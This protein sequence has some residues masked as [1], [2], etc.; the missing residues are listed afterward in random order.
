MRPIRKEISLSLGAICLVLA[1]CGGGDDA[2]AG[3]G[4]GNGLGALGTS[5]DV[6]Q[7]YDS[8]GRSI[9]PMYCIRPQEGSDWADV[10]SSSATLSMALESDR[11][12]IARSIGVDIK[13]SYSIV[14]ASTSFYRATETD[15]FSAA[16]VFGGAISFKE[17]QVGPDYMV[18]PLLAA[19]NPVEW[20]E[21]CGDSFVHGISRGASLYAAMKFHFKSRSEK[22]TFEAKMKVSSG[23]FSVSSAL[24]TAQ[25]ISTQGVSVSVSAIQVGGDVTQLNRVLNGASAASC[26]MSDVKKCLDFMDSI[27]AYV[28]N[29]FPKQF[30]DSQGH[31]LAGNALD[32]MISTVDYSVRPWTDLVLPSQPNLRG[33]PLQKQLLDQFAKQF[34][35]RSKIDDIRGIP[36]LGNRGSVMAEKQARALLGVENVIAQ[37]LQA[38]EQAWGL[39]YPLERTDCSS[40]VSSA[41]SQQAE[42]A[43]EN[44]QPWFDM[45][46]VGGIFPAHENDL[47]DINDDGRKELC[48]SLDDPSRMRLA[49]IL[50]VG[51]GFEDRPSIF[52]DGAPLSSVWNVIPG[53]GLYRCSING[54]SSWLMCA[55]YKDRAMDTNQSFAIHIDPKMELDVYDYQNNRTRIP[56]SDVPAF[57][58]QDPVAFLRDAVTRLNNR[59][60]GSWRS[61]PLGS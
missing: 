17:R 50:P 40:A 27:E 30:R 28:S 55:K 25:S 61:W 11:T 2:P 48:Y 31:V 23:L 6:G 21:Y 44:L 58:G 24:K 56:A 3:T 20:R 12:K 45:L 37:N 33:K 46:A 10:G 53:K 42:V 16:Y 41:M 35:L 34:A 51:G 14:S 29:D 19:V 54:G 36:I 5:G 13:A 49:C 4:G 57:I 15:D 52:M 7:G 26:S 32:R 59:Y 47:V 8:V 9:K 60:P 38:L 39:C 1:G 22:Q 18:N 43:P